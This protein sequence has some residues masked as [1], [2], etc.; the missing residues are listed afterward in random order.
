MFIAGHWHLFLG[1]ESL[2]GAWA[3]RLAP[4]AAGPQE[5]VCK[6][7]RKEYDRAEKNQISSGVGPVSNAADSPGSGRP[8]PDGSEGNAV[9]EGRE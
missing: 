1:V 6:L 8:A 4:P 2:C 7:C 9:L 5:P 3:V